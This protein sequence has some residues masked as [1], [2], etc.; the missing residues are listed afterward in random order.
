MIEIFLMSPP[1]PG[2]AL[3]GRANF[4][5]REA[6]PVDAAKARGEWLRLAEEIEARGGTVVALPP[7]AGELTGMPYAAECGHV[8]VPA[9]GGAPRFILPRMASPHRQGEGAHWQSLARA[10]GFDVVAPGAGVWEA[11]GDV[12]EMDGAT[13]L[14]FGGRTDRAGMEAAA[15]HIEGELLRIEVREPAFHGNMAALPLPEV[16]RMLIC[17]DVVVGDGMARLQERFGDKALVPVSEAEIKSYATNGLPLGFSLLA[18]SVVPERVR[19]LCEELGMRVVSLDMGELCE[20]AG[21]ASRCLVSRA[22]V[23]DEVAARIPAE[24]RLAAV[25]A[26]I[27]GG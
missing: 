16:G 26:G 8:V 25:A 3:R 2:W 23:P 7:P 17:P 19:T 27:R 22:R 13:L 11:Q 9:A 18:P 21:G 14:F 12:A 6:P 5:S 24:N 15:R 20:K 1:G 10:L 4:R